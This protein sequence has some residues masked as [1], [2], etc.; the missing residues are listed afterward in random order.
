LWWGHRIPA[1][2]GTDGRIFVAE[3]ESQAYQKAKAAG[4]DGDLQQDEDVLDTWFSSALVPFSTLNEGLERDLFL[5]SS[6]LI[7][8]FD[9][10]FFWA[11]RMVMMTAHLTGKIP[12]KTLYIH[13]LVRDAEGKKMSKSTGNTLDPLDLIEGIELAPLL[14]KRTNGLA[15]PHDAPKVAKQT[16][17]EFPSG[18]PAYGTDALRFTFA[19]LAGPGRNINF[20]QKRCEG[21]RHFCNKLWNATRFVLMNV[22]GHDSGQNES[23]SLEHSVID[24]WII[25]RLQ[26][27]EKTMEE[28]FATYRFDLAAQALYQFVWEEYCDWYVELAKVQLQNGNEVQQRTTRRTLIRVLEV[29]LRL[30]HPLLPFI[31]ETLWQSLQPHLRT[32]EQGATIA[33]RSYPLFNAERVDLAAEQEVARLQAV[34]GAAR[35]LR[36]ELQLPPSERVPMWVRC[37]S[38]ADHVWYENNA[39]YL[40]ALAKLS[41]VKTMETLPET[42]LASALVGQDTVMLK[43]EI[44]PV[45]ERARL[46]KEI[47]RLEGEIEKINGKLGNEGFVARAPEAV[48]AQERERLAQFQSQL[49]KVQEQRRLVG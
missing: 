45:K 30:A 22:E 2:Y 47:T 35:N 19:S 40:M 43:I 32:S 37:V 14:E 49:V 25:S 48:V 46:D 20:D 29:V 34:T 6:V 8:G 24:R 36:S 7:T 1:W 13:G 26:Q 11:A 41:E 27:L 5:P 33:T 12:F 28:G 16:E 21:Y 23:V 42:G 9:I 31:T 17:K 44:D 3:D 15:R 39:A 18:I 4:Y 10:L 38:Q